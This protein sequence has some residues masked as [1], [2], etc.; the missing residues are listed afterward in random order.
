[1]RA[2][3]KVDIRKMTYRECWN[4]GSVLGILMLWPAKFFGM[5]LPF[6]S[7]IPYPVGQR[8]FEIPEAQLPQ[9][10]RHRLARS[11]DEFGRLGFHSPRFFLFQSRKQETSSYFITMLHSSGTCVLRLFCTIANN[12]PVRL[13]KCLATLLTQFEDGRYLVASDG[14]PQF[15]ASPGVVVHRVIGGKPGQLFGAHEKRVAEYTPTS[16]PRRVTTA[17]QL[18]EIADRYEKYCFDCSL[19]RGLYVLM[20]PNETTA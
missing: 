5:N 3:Y 9:E 7:G 13:V 18:D 10:V 20:H 12:P 8:E 2:Y 4:I 1:M 6:G 14:K 17:E 16:T 19:Q 11:Y 15:M